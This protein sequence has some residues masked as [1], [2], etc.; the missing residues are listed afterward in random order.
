[1][2]LPVSAG[3]GS[4]KHLEYDLYI[5]LTTTATT[6]TKKKKNKKKTICSNKN[7]FLLCWTIDHANK[8]LLIL[9]VTRGK[10][11]NLQFQMSNSE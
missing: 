6:T 2:M 8:C 7:F 4:F 5:T 9:T 3:R 10:E 1:M 11:V